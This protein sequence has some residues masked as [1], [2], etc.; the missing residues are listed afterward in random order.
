MRDEVLVLL[1]WPCEAGEGD[2]VNTGLEI[3]R[4]GKEEEGKLFRQG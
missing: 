1:P 3:M 2:S 4:R